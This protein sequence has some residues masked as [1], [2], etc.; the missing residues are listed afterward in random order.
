MTQEY[1]IYWTSLRRCE[2]YAGS[3]AEALGIFDGRG[4]WHGIELN[5]DDWAIFD[6]ARNCVLNG[7]NPHVSTIIIP[8]SLAGEMYPGCFWKPTRK[9]PLTKS[10][11]DKLDSRSKENT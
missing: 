8:G 4:I 11:R 6:E 5:R 1:T 7:G 2:I 9:T 3:A 10:A